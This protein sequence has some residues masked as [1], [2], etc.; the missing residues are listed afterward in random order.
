MRVKH[1]FEDTHIAMLDLDA[2]VL[3]VTAPPFQLTRHYYFRYCK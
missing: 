2:P 1:M 3:E